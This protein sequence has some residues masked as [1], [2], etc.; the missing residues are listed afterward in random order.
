MSDLARIHT[1]PSA[2]SDRA[3]AR[4]VLGDVLELHGRGRPFTGATLADVRFSTSTD[5]AVTCPDG[6]PVDATQSGP[7]ACRLGA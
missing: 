1:L 7:A 6:L 4:L 5:P 3:A 2:D